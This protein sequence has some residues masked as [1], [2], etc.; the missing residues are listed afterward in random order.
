MINRNCKLVRALLYALINKIPFPSFCLTQ[1]QSHRAP[2]EE[3]SSANTTYFQKSFI[4]ALWAKS[5]GQD[6]YKI[7]VPENKQV[8]MET[9]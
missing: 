4:T 7:T 5:I 1:S 6:Q 3:N 9:F 2:R 8:S